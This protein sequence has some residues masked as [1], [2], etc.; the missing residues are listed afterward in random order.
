MTKPHLLRQVQLAVC[1]GS[2]RLPTC[3]SSKAI[4]QSPWPS[5]PTCCARSSLP[6]ASASSPSWRHLDSLS[7]AQEG[8]AQIAIQMQQRAAVGSPNWRHLD[9]L[10]G[11]PR[12]AQGDE[13]CESTN[14]RTSALP[15]S[16]G[17]S[18]VLPCLNASLYANH[19]AA[20]DWLASLTRLPR[21]LQRQLQQAQPHRQLKLVVCTGARRK[22]VVYR[23]AC[24]TMASQCQGQRNKCGLSMQSR[25]FR[26]RLAG[27]SRSTHCARM[28]LHKAAA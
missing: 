28:P 3:L 8:R 13:T 19:P 22:H 20:A 2:L 10:S 4:D 23:H 24:P 7:G 12:E 9:S 6:F 27:R 16:S 14:V 11:A 21:Q 18:A 25:H 5:S 17:T 1:S 15:T 26:D